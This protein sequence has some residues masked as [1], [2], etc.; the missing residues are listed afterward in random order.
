MA[1]WK[2]GPVLAAG[3]SLVL[4]PTEKPPLTAIRI[5]QI[6]VVA[7]VPEGVFNVVPGFGQ[8]AGKALTLHMDVDCIAFTGSTGTG[9]NSMQYAG[10]SNMKRVSLECGGKSPNIVLADCPDLDMAASAAAYAIFDNQ[11]EVC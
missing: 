11:G 2:I 5:A 7:G 1:A 8:T 3:N 4:K 10:Q 9:R 6:T